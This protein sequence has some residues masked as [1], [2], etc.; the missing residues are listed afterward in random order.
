MSPEPR[1]SGVL[2]GL[3]TTLLLAAAFTLWVVGST[4][5]PAEMAELHDASGAGATGVRWARIVLTRCGNG[6][7]LSNLM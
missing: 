1:D 2:L 3:A 6:I 4:T 7:P 5:T